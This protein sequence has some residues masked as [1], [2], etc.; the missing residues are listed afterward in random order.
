VL[1]D[2]ALMLADGG[3]AIAD[4]DVLRHQGQVLGPVASSEVCVEYL[5]P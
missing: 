4:I 2:V 5:S 1:V 3:Q